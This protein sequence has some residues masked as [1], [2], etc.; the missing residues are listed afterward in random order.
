LG[1]PMRL[2][3]PAKLMRKQL[4]T[5]ADT[6]NRQSTFQD[7]LIDRRRALIVDAIRA[8]GKNN[9]LRAKRLNVGQRRG[10]GK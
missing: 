4:H 5:I 9:A 10:S 1:V 8:T 7:C 2:D 6:Q 3:A